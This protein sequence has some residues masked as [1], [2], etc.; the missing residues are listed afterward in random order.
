MLLTWNAFHLP[1]LAAIR[2]LVSRELLRALISRTTHERTPREVRVSFSR[3]LDYQNFRGQ[4]NFPPLFINAKSFSC[5][6]VNFCHIWSFSWP[7]SCNKTRPT[8]RRPEGNTSGSLETTWVEFIYD[9]HIIQSIL[10]LQA[11]GGF[12]RFLEYFSDSNYEF[13]H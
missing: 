9:Y 5:T 7:F 2:D 1:L 8:T 13:K 10:R 12:V 11:T 4:R 6:N 3:E